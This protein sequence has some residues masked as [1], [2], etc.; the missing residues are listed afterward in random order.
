MPPGELKLCA[1]PGWS[2]KRWTIWAR[3]EVKWKPDFVLWGTVLKNIQK[4]VLNLS[5]QHVGGKK[6]KQYFHWFQKITWL[7]A[8]FQGDTLEKEV[9]VKNPGF[10]V[11]SAALYGLREGAR[12]WYDRFYRRCLSLGF[13]PAPWDPAA[14][15][16]DRD[17]ARGSLAI[18]VGDMLTAGNALFYDLV[19]VP[20]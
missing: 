1:E 8:F 18:H 14:Y 20:C 4:T 17:G 6:W 15:N 12:N 16:Y 5:L 19:I 13:T 11:L 10:W 9:L 7:S 3:R 2:Q